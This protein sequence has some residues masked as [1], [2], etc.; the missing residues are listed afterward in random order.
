MNKNALLFYI[1]VPVIWVVL[2][3]GAFSLKDSHSFLF[4]IS[5]SVL[6][7]WGFIYVLLLFFKAISSITRVYYW[8]QGWHYEDDYPKT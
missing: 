7:I 1:L 2:L 3:I 4:F 8:S 6:F 5:L